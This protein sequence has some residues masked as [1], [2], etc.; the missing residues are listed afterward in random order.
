MQ[1][2]DS[3]AVGP[4]LI[5]PKEF[6]IPATGGCLELQVMFT[7]PGVGKFSEEIHMA[8]DNGQVLTYTLAGKSMEDLMSPS[9]FSHNQQ[10]P[11]RASSYMR[12]L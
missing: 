11:D 10:R 8:C 6:S 7:P 1:E 5:S 9:N 12:G 3:I 4:F 2:T